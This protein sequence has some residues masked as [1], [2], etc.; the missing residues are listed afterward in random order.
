MSWHDT[1]K[2]GSRVLICTLL[3]F[4][5]PL[6]LFLNGVILNIECY[7]QM[8]DCGTGSH[9]VEVLFNSIQALCIQVLAVQVLAGNVK[10]FPCP[11]IARCTSKQEVA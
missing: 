2:Q 1:G 10:L 9:R 5:P 4:T 8:S 11:D 7:N 6:L 3:L